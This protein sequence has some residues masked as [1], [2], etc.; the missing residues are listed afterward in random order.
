M[1]PGGLS[2]ARPATPEVQE[3]ADKVRAQLEEQ[4]NEKYEKYEAD[5]Y[6]TQVVAGVNYFIKINLGDGSF[7]HIKVYKDL[8]G[9]LKLTG[10]QTKKTKDD[11]LT[12]F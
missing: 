9:N 8:S 4:T 5:Q 1:I 2:E 11:E 10:Y 3:I 12:Y 6:K 7:I